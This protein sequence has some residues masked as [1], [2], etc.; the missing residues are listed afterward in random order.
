MGA[1]EERR[2][3]DVLFESGGSCY[4]FTIRE[5]NKRIGIAPAVVTDTLLRPS[6][7]EEAQLEAKGRFWRA[8]RAN[9]GSRDGSRR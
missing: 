6:S 4:I 7:G 2:I 1:S 9:G 5:E 8:A 3:R